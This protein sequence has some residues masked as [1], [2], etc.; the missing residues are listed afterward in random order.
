MDGRRYAVVESVLPER[1]VAPE[2]AVDPL[3]HG[4]GLFLREVHAREAPRLPDHVRGDLLG[5]FLLH[6]GPEGSGSSVEVRPTPEK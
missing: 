1:G 4:F 3:G 2:V 6:A 5:L